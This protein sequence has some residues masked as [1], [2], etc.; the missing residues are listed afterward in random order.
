MLVEYI[1]HCDPEKIEALSEK[2]G[3]SLSEDYVAFLKKTNGVISR[4]GK[5]FYVKGLDAEIELDSL[6]GFTADRDWL[7]IEFWMKMYAS[8][9]PE[10]T[11]ILGTDVLDNFLIMIGSGENAGVY[12]WDCSFS[13]AKSTDD[14][15]AYYVTDSFSGFRDLMG[16]FIEEEK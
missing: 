1:K 11:V 2:Y 3:L 15:N 12:Y 10:N 6:Y 9:L 8:E 5:T 13:F 7:D 14:S 16:D 4:D